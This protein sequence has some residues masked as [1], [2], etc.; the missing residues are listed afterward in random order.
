[1]GKIIVPY[2]D[3]IS[4]DTKGY[5]DISKMVEQAIKDSEQEIKDKDKNSNKLKK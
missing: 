1:M 5:V 4:S 2:G 3:G